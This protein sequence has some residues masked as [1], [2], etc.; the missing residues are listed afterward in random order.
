MDSQGCYR[1]KPCLKKTQTKITKNQTNDRKQK[2]YSG[3]KP[4]LK[5][6]PNT[7]PSAD[8]FFLFENTLR[9]KLWDCKFQAARGTNRAVLPDT[10][11]K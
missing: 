8:L 7:V 9:Q 4:K 5:K 11:P 10:H 1:E 2:T 6:L 3:S